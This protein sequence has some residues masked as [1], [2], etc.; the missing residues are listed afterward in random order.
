MFRNTLSSRQVSLADAIHRAMAVIE[1][2]PQGTILCANPAFYKASGYSAETLVGCHHSLLCPRELVESDEYA[3]FWPRL[4]EGESISG[5]CKRLRQDGTPLW[6][7]ATYHPIPDRHGQVVRVIKIAT[8]ITVQVRAEQEMDSRLAAINRSMAVIELTPDGHILTANQNFLDTVGYRLE[9]IEGEHHRIFCGKALAASPE[10]R[11]FWAQLNAGEYVSGQFKRFDRQGRTLWLEATYNPIFDDGGRLYKVIK[12]ASNI[13]ERVERE[14]ESLRLACR[15]SADTENTAD[16]GSR[17]ID[18]TVREIRSIADRVEATSRLLNDLTAQ[19]AGITAIVE[20]IQ[21]IAA[22]TNLLSLNAAIEA[23]RAGEH[24]RGFS[25][26]A[27]EVRALARRTAEATSEIAGTVDTL[28]TLS[29]SASTSMHTCQESV[30]KGV[31]MAGDAGRAIIR[32]SACTSDMV[33]AVR[34]MASSTELGDQPCT[35]VQ[36]T[37]ALGAVE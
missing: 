7:E 17:I 19:A 22:Q 29:H 36:A 14:T 26:V 18:E 12:F 33:M 15:I 34:N 28:Q 5:R 23:A 10:Y 11:A 21:S 24:G 37:E 4:R 6:L 3:G 16:N 31:G 9:E 25:V 30:E 1:F 32:I 35:Q 20:T 13:T 27:H 8:D 2:D